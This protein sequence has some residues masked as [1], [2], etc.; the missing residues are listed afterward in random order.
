M[1]IKISKTIIQNS[2][3]KFNAMTFLPSPNEEHKPLMAIFT[4]GYTASKRDCLPWA[5][6]LAESGIPS[7][8]FDLPGHYLGSFEEVESFKDFKDHAHENFIDAHRYLIE[9]LKAHGYD[10]N[11][12]TLILGG[13]SLGA[14]LTLKALELDYFKS[15]NTYGVCVGLGIGQHKT[16]HLFESSFYQKTLDVRRQLVSPALDSDVVFPWIKQEKLNMSITGKKIH[17]ICGVDDVVVGPGGVEALAFNL[18]ELGN[19]VSVH[20]PKKLPH[21]EPTMAA[22]HINSFVKKNLL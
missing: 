15:M 19:D 10:T 22:T 14:M 16:T 11:F 9:Q 4:H 17:L 3:F 1:S 6:R 5:Q 20:E 8:I 7:V 12:E 2:F 18:Q 21:H 13:H